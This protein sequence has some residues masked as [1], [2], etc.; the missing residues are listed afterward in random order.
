MQGR[1]GDYELFEELGRG[2]M[3]VVSRARE[4]ARGRIVALK[5]LLRGPASTPQDLERFRIEALAAAR[6]AHPHIVPVFQV[7]E[8]DGQPYFTMQYIEGTTLAQQLAGGPLPEHDAAR[9]LVPVCRA[10][11]YAHDRGVLHRDLKPS[12]ILIDRQGN[13]YVSDFGL[14]KRIDVDPTLTPSGAFLGTPSYMP[15]EQAGSIASGRRDPLGPTAD[16]YSLGAIL[17]HMLTGRPPFQAATPIETML[18]AL[19]HDPIAPRALNPRVN[20]DLEMVAL[21]CLQK[22]PGA[23]LSVGRGPGRGSRV[24]PA[25]RSG[26]GALD[27]PPRTGRPA[28]GRDPS[29]ACAGKLG[30]ALDLPQHRPLGLLRHDQL[31]VP[32]GCDGALALCIDLHGRALRL[33]GALLGPAPPRRSDP[34][35]RTPAR[36]RLG[37]RDRLHQ[38]DLPG[39]VA[40]GIARAQA[41]P[42]D[43]RHQRHAVH[44]QGGHPFGRLLPA[45]GRDVSGHL[46]HGCWFPRFRLPLDS[47]CG[48]CVALRHCFFVTGLKYRA[49]AGPAIPTS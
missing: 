10:I 1:F 45:G 22:P 31:A 33:G 6:L 19:E 34:V 18:L 13:P 8:C 32:R 48:S 7:G 4:I 46:S 16:V 21:Q 44:D 12:N 14:A 5:R 49:A 9:L 24:V 42:D 15:P 30:L 28:H 37:C 36:P 17:Y 27:E 2:G 47:S 39:R 3:G 23:A 20:P 11:H 35:R 26:V 40:A 43:R 38:P 29:C 25:R 41:R